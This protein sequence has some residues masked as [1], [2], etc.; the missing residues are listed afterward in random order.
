MNLSAVLDPLLEPIIRMRQRYFMLILA[1]FSLPIA[2]FAQPVTQPFTFSPIEHNLPLVRHGSTS[3]G[4]IDGD[5]DLDLFLSGESE[6]GIVSA[7]FRNDGF[8]GNG[9][10][11]F[12]EVSAVL[13]RVAFS[14][15]S[16]GDADG[17][18]DLD[19]VV[20]GSRTISYPY[21]PVTSMYR[22]DGA[23]FVS[24]SADLPRLHSGSV[25]WGDL[26]NDGD[27][28][29]L[30]T[31]T[32]ENDAETSSI[33]NRNADGS[34]SSV[35]DAL[36]GI[37]YGDSELGDVDG[38]GDLDAVIA[39]S[40]I[41]GFTT[42]VYKNN[43]GTLTAMNQEFGE[44]AFASADLGDYDNDGDL[45]LITGGGQIS[46]N[47]MDGA[48][49]LW[50][51]SGG[52]F[53]EVT[54]S[55]NGI[56]A[57]DIS[58]GD[59]D[60]DGD[61]DLMVLGANNILGRRDASIYQNDGANGFVNKSILV[62]SI[63]SDMEWGDFDGDGDLDLLTSGF[64][65]YGQTA[66]TLYQNNRQVI[67]TVPSAPAGLQSRV[68]NSSVELNWLPTLQS[69]GANTFLTF[70]V[71]IGT[72]PG[73]TDLVSSM[74]NFQTGRL[75][76]PQPGNATS[77]M[78]MHLSN[79]NDGIYYWSVQAVNNAFIASPF[80]DEGSFSVSGG[81]SVDTETD[82]ALPQ[83]FAIRP[84]YPN[85]FASKTTIEYD[86]PETANVSFIVY[87]MLGQE[88]LRLNPGAQAAGRHQLEWT[89]ED[90]SGS[91]VGS[92]I[93]LF[94]LRAGPRVKSGTMTL[95]R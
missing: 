78:S 94:E 44:F 51:N 14:A 19:L 47:L 6:T 91:R 75:Q 9:K 67:P 59:Y 38:D 88:I 50:N 43:S 12:T 86:L 5:G 73:G 21:D 61:L 82:S 18:G 93:Y 2:A 46:S 60:H 80:S 22:N 41:N 24:V 16:W 25:S 71:R 48:V 85:P 58:F 49:R 34:Y 33:A 28:D 36:P 90:A 17:D 29:L 69:D 70:N 4:D 64:T 13:D 79:L 39:G 26:D 87:S 30:L 11:L 65:P 55:A 31:G 62:G 54:L 68:E 27:L 74:S 40:G 63:F 45:D 56:L 81:Q 57:G 7:I 3:W 89:G 76:T 32:D 53:T 37:A 8:D 92:G 77:N 10:A 95:V 66:T 72:T 84:N 20:M 42:Q 15:S 35:S 83:H 1:A 23:T 52:S